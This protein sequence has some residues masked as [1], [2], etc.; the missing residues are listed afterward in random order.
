MSTWED[1][2]LYRRWDS[3]LVRLRG[4]P[5]LP[6]D[7]LDGIDF[8]AHQLAD[9]GISELL[10]GHEQGFFDLTPEEEA[11]LWDLAAEWEI[12]DDA[13]MNDY[14]R[15]RSVRD[16]PVPRVRPKHPL[17]GGGHG[18]GRGLPGRREFPATWSDDAVMDAT[19]EVARSPEG[20]RKLPTGDWRAWG[21]R[22]G[23]RLSV[24]LDG[25]GQVLTSYPVDGPGVVQNPLD[26]WRTEPVARLQAVLAATAP[27]DEAL[28]ELLAVGEWPHV[29]RS[30]QAL[31][32]ELDELARLAGL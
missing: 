14:V 11:E 26:S 7:E 15:E 23:V 5:G 30:L 18:P 8:R 9:L 1:A 32:V 29:V 21:T 20:A 17:R 10:G 24:L 4:R 28:S 31:G 6:D 2:P 27:E 13:A 3:L 22:R 25:D 12:T 16:R 19:L